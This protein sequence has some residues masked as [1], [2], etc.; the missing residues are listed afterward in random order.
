MKNQQR[1]LQPATS[2]GQQLAARPALPCVGASAPWSAMG[3]RVSRPHVHVAVRG[4]RTAGVIRP[5]RNLS[6][7]CSIRRQPASLLMQKFAPRFRN[8]LRAKWRLASQV[9]ICSSCYIRLVT[10][11]W[12]LDDGDKPIIQRFSSI[13][14]QRGCI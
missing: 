2:G 9:I 4:S 3:R 11:T 5:I 6:I 1:F 7:T 13:K 8:I 14:R 12:M 10:R